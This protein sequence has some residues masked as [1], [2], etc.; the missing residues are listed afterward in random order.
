MTSHPSDDMIGLIYDACVRP[1]GW[2]PFLN[3]F[4]QRLSA[5]LTV[6]VFRHRPY[7]SLTLMVNEAGLEGTDFGQSYWKVA[8]ANPINYEAME[9][10]R[11]YA[12][13][14]FVPHG[15]VSASPFFSEHLQPAGLSHLELLAIGPTDGFRAHLLWVRADEKGPLDGDERAWLAALIPHLERSMAIFG[16]LKLSQLAADICTGALNQLAFGIVALNKDGRILFCNRVAEDLIDQSEDLNRLDRRLIFRRRD[17]AQTIRELATSIEPARKEAVLRLRNGDETIGV[18]ARPATTGDP[19]SAITTARVIVYFHALT[20]HVQ[21]SPAL[22]KQLFGL[23][24]SEAALAIQLSEGK[25]LREA[26]EQLGITENSARTYS[27]RIFMKAG[28]GR[29]TDLVRIIL[30]SVAMLG[31]DD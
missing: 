7:G 27:K 4:Y 22:L 24:P 12:L 31:L 25:T 17:H 23:A 28:V 13:R 2:Q 15:D 3:A 16:R 6:M 30:R 11:I 20:E 8:G 5:Y 9:S 14:D 19:E 26:A 18:L 29:Q 21:P 10:G 1:E